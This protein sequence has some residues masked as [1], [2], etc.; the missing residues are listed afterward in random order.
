MK[1]LKITAIIFTLIFLILY[2]I[3]FSA[4]GNAFVASLVQ[5]Q[6]DKA[7]GLHSRFEKFSLSMGSLDIVLFLTPHN[8]VALKGSYG[9][10]SQSFDLRYKVAYEELRELR[11][12][13]LQ[14]IEGSFHTEGNIKGDLDR[15]KI[16]GESDIARSKTTYDVELTQLQPTSIIAKI[17][18]LD[19]ATLLH[20]A[21]QKQYAH[22]K[23]F[24]DANFKDITPHRLDGTV[25]LWTKEGR[26]EPK[27][28]QKDFNITLPPTNF[29]MK[30]HSKLHGDEIVY[31]YL[32][33]SNL[34]RITTKGKVIPQPLKSDVVY[35][36][37][38]K[39]LAL[40]E[41]IVGVKIRGGLNA[42]GSVKG[43]E[44]SMRATLH[45]DVA[46]S[47]TDVAVE[48]VH[49]KPKSL[50]ADIRHLKVQ[51]LLWM[52]HQPHYTS[53]D[54]DVSANMKELDMKR[55]QGEVQVSLKGALD[56]RYLTKAYKFAH[57]MPP[58]NYTLTST[59]KIKDAVADSHVQLNSSLA[60][61]DIKRAS[62]DLKSAKLQSDFH[63]SVPKLEKLYFVTDRH[64]RGGLLANGEVM[65]ASSSLQLNAHS[66]IAG[67]KLDV[68]MKNDDLLVTLDDMRTK[69]V[70]WI[71][72]Y[73]EIF[74]GGVNANVKYNLAS[75]KGVLKAKFDKG[76]F[77]KNQAFDLLKQYGKIDLYKER[78]D[79][80]AT[81]EIKKEKV[82][83][84]FKLVSRK[85]TIESKKTY[86]DTKRNTIDSHITLKTKKAPL[87][88]TLKGDM[89]APKVGVDLKEFMK[90]E[91]GKELEKKAKKEVDRLFKKLF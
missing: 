39:E 84:R 60:K 31:D 21:G 88:I 2:A 6:I 69:K 41:P 4:P 64:L 44:K 43:D 87:G 53:A 19:V 71:L 66:K 77:L 67:G 52:L 76:V 54:I 12:I 59:T 40:F 56:S 24:V 28:F 46:G 82:Q 37:K 38:V 89:N 50:V 32:L 47:K 23:L 78:F 18:A 51:N 30:L 13:V 35:S 80:D 27:V 9:L 11:E 68:T 48:L 33:D 1:I 15:M 61:L 55:L 16:T 17:E 8:S 74:D 45:S 34:A 25:S 79:G 83:A 36:M 85:A 86:I 57:P 10:L 7:T 70:L 65:F 62:Y 20:M 72:K 63:I 81:A 49:L 73:P 42:K 29:S 22:S 26:I 14:P 5:K 90:S 91:A 58:T 75:S 3:L